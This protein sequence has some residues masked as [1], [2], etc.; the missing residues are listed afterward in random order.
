MCAVQIKTWCRESDVLLSRT[1][2]RLRTLLLVRV[3]LL[4]VFTI[5]SGTAFVHILNVPVW[6]IVRSIAWSQALV[7]FACTVR[8]YNNN[9]SLVHTSKEGQKSKALAFWFCGI[10]SRSFERPCI[11]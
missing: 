7:R 3:G 1:P 9:K 11:C 10:R 4:D 5:R 8:L 6:Y 2:L